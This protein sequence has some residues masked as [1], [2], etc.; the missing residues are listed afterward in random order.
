MKKVKSSRLKRKMRRKRS[1]GNTVVS[2]RR[3]MVG[4]LKNP[5]RLDFNAEALNTGAVNASLFKTM[6]AKNKIEKL[7][8][9]GVTSVPPNIN[10]ESALTPWQQTKN[11]MSI[12][13]LSSLG[14]TFIEAPTSLLDEMNKDED[15]GLIPSSKYLGENTL[16][17]TENLLDLSFEEK[18]KSI[19]SETEID[20]DISQVATN[21]IGEIFNK[22]INPSDN[23]IELFGKKK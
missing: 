1:N 10:P 21:I 9:P 8:H 4:G 11:V 12:G 17:T 6:V 22:V 20:I 13:V 15:A 19:T 18:K 7:N 5:A 16:F 23:N 2:P 14:V 3:F